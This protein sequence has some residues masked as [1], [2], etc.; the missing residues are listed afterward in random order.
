M[1]NPDPQVAIFARAVS[2]VR[3]V[4]SAFFGQLRME[5]SGVSAGR[6]AQNPRGGAARRRRE[7]HKRSFLRHV[8]FHR[9]LCQATSSHHTDT[10]GGTQTEQQQ[11]LVIA[12]VQIDKLVKRVEDLEAQLAA[13]VVPQSAQQ[14]QQLPQPRPP[15]VV[16]G[17]SVVHATATPDVAVNTLEEMEPRLQRQAD[18][19]EPWLVAPIVEEEAEHD[20]AVVT[21]CASM[22]HKMGQ[23]DPNSDHNSDCTE[24]GSESDN[25]SEDDD[26]PEDFNAARAEADAALAEIAARQA[27][28]AARQRYLRS[29]RQEPDAG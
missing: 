7:Q 28:I 24:K 29:R 10:A 27:E 11:R 1:R 22:T 13:F 20:K 14:Q 18:G 21:P 2:L 25:L 6:P 23:G 26:D 16:Q 5:T 8:E 12:T 9:R 15:G 19:A 3:A 17:A 4:Q